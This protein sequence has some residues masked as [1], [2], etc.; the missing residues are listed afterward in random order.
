[1]ARALG[2][3][4]RPGGHPGPHASSSKTHFNRC[5]LGTASAYATRPTIEGATDD[6]AQAIAVL[7]GLAK[8]DQY[9]AIRE[10]LRTQQHSSPY[11]EKYVGEALL[12]RDAL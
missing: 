5:L 9:P 8:P 3:T 6:R 11:V 1:M 7:A 12:H 10:L 2:E 4:R